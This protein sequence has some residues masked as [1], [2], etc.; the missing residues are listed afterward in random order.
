MIAIACLVSWSC[1]PEE[2][3]L[4]QQP[5]VSEEAWLSEDRQA[6]DR[7]ED[8]LMLEEYLWYPYRNRQEMRPMPEANERHQ[9]PYPEPLF[10]YQDNDPFR[11]DSI[12]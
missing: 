10:F 7:W 12:R 11:D 1:V 4:T 2:T 3:P 8:S 6:A 9:L 5:K